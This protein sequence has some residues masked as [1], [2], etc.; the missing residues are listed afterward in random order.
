MKCYVVRVG[1]YSD[2]YVGGV[3][4]T[5][6]A[7]MA[8]FPPE[9]CDSPWCKAQNA[10]VWREVNRSYS[11]WAQPREWENQCSSSVEISEYEMGELSEAQR[12][13]LGDDL[14]YDFEARP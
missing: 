12:N 5:P 2:Q 6:E 1:E 10:H 7:A 11:D 8:A 4:P 14:M 3:Y 9:Y 13:R